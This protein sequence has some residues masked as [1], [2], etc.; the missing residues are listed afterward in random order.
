[1]ITFNVRK[2]PQAIEAYQKFLSLD[3]GQNSNQDWQ[4]QQRIAV[5]RHMLESKR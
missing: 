4:A 5:L 3:N 2:M 1:M